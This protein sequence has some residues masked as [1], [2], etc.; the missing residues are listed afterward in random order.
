MSNRRF[1]TAV[2]WPQIRTY[3]LNRESKNRLQ[4]QVETFLPDTSHN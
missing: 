1:A 3:R 4:L 2:L